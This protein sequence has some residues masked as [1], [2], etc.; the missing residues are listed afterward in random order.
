MGDF[1]ATAIDGESIYTYAY[2]SNGLTVRFTVED[3]I[4]YQL[5][6]L[7]EN[8]QITLFGNNSGTIFNI[9]N[10]GVDSGTK[11]GN[12][13]PDDYEFFIYTGGEGS[14]FGE[15]GGYDVEFSVSNVPLP[16]GIWLLGTG[17]IGIIGIR[18]KLKK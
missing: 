12:L 1:N 18:R 14:E 6:W 13:A 8:A 2:A 17:L 7:S 15:Y 16:G 3:P 11:S 9:F 5:D 10:L 4:Y